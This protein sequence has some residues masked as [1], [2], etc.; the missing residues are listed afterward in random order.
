GAQ[1]VRR[2]RQGP[3]LTQRTI[4]WLTRVETVGLYMALLA[5][6]ATVWLAS[7]RGIPVLDELV[8]VT[9]IMAFLFV[10]LFAAAG[11]LLWSHQLALPLSYP[12][13]AAAAVP[14]YVVI[15]GFL[16]F[17]KPSLTIGS[18]A[19]GAATAGGDLG[20]FLTSSLIGIALW[21]LAVVAFT[22]IVWPQQVKLTL[23]RT[24]GALATVWSWQIPHKVWH[25]VLTVVDFAFPTKAPPDESP[26]SHAPDWLPD[27]EEEDELEPEPLPVALVKTEEPE[28]PDA[29]LSQGQL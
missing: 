17:I 28:I 2:R 13:W 12:R 3:S 10:W 22:V 9:G 20:A 21:L 7:G 23:E 4:Y 29:R 1:P 5:L 19:L 15:A 14:G 11:I 18:V 26:L 24:P 25:G 8:Q 27:D 6:I 16:G